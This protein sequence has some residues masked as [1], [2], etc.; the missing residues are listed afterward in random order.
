M[1]MRYA[2]PGCCV[3]YKWSETDHPINCLFPDDAIGT[4]TV[5]NL[6]DSYLTG[7][8]EFWREESWGWPTISVFQLNCNVTSAARDYI[9]LDA[10]TI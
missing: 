4:G 9:A 6:R 10:N 8:L 5:V 1:R 7:F 3:G 2:L